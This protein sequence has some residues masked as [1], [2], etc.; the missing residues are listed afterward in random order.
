[1][2]VSTG[3]GAP[4]REACARWIAGR[5]L[6]YFEG[7][8]PAPARLARYAGILRDADYELE[9]L[10]SALFQDPAFYGDEVVGTRISGPVEYLVGLEFLTAPDG[11]AHALA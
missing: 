7:R 5:L 4:E 8:E 2:V 10:L 3:T 1:M 9:P 11:W 6:A